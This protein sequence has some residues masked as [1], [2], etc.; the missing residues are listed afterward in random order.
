MALIMVVLGMAV[1]VM[2]AET[3]LPNGANLDVFITTPETCTEFLIPA[4]Q[5]TIPV[6]VSGTASAGLGDPDA[7]LVYVVDVSGS[8]DNGGGT[9]CSPILGCEKIFIIALNE[10]AAD[11]GSVSDVGSVVFA[12]TAATADMDGAGG[13]QLLTPPDS[14]SVNLPTVVNSMFSVYGGD[15]GVS[16]FTPKTVG[17]STNF[18][19]A[20]QQALVVVQASTKGHKIVVFASDGVSNVGTLADFNAAVS[21][22][23]AE[24]AKIYSVAV[25]T[26]ST[27]T[28]GLAGTLQAM[29]DATGGTCTEVADPGLLPVIIPDLISTEL[30]SLALVVDGGAPTVLS[31]ADI[32]PDLPAAGAVA[33]TYSTSVP[34]LGP[35]DHVISV[36]ATGED[37]TALPRTVTDEVTIHLYQITLNPLVM[38]NELGTPGQTHTVTATL[39]GPLGGLAPVSGR[40]IIFSILTGP[41]A[42]ASGICDPIDCTTDAN[43]DV[44]FTY[45][46][47]QG[48]A[49]LGTDTIQASITL[50]NP[51]GETGTVTA[52][53]NWR[54]TTPPIPDCTETVNPAGKKVPPAG[55]TTLPGAKGGQNEDGFYRLTATDA[56]DPSPQVF[57]QDTGSGEI[58]GP[59]TS[60]TTIKYTE[61]STATP[62]QKSI[63]GPN[64][65][66]AWHIKGTGDAAVIAVDASGNTA[67]AVACF[68]PPP[69]K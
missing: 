38:D 36:T 37:V 4:G 6:Y 24:N 68:V 31:N 29:A 9:G 32:D 46:A 43:G 59:F 62:V 39:L 69:P 50:N 18:A 13:E 20:L 11:S 42:G 28:G 65:A 40:E 12:D 56:V 63:G 33:V 34:A 30:T 19:A 5:D 47:A 26:G 27:C 8:T 44:S 22:L 3:T 64:S 2:A 14:G 23:G 48:L 45:T 66:V 1:P 53:K 41:N 25:G 52:V 7:T 21:A 17:I 58:F 35:G 57:V 49:G 51:N 16:L 67:D 61:D 15:G 55:S 54:D 10:A 60:G